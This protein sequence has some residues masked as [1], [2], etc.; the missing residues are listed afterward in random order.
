MRCA[1]ICSGSAPLCFPAETT[2]VLVVSGPN[3]LQLCPVWREGRWAQCVSIW[4]V[5]AL[6]IET[7]GKCEAWDKLR[8][9]PLGLNLWEGLT[10]YRARFS[11]HTVCNILLCFLSS[12]GT[13]DLFRCN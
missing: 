6:L 2:P 10:S 5:G 9:D 8:F 13:L 11:R 12:V 1:V 3:G 7:E 4:A